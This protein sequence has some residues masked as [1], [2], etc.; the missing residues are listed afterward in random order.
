MGLTT[1]HLVP[2]TATGGTLA[3]LEHELAPRSL[4]SPL[5]THRHEDEV[6]HV[7]SG[8]L[9]VQVG[10]AVLELGPGETVAKP[11][12][13]AHAFWN[14]GDVPVRFLEVVTPAGFEAYFAEVEPLLA[15]PG[16]PDLIAVGAL[17]ARYGLEVDPFSIGALVVA[18]DLV[19]PLPG[20]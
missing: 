9:G 10:D 2:G 16:A 3:L 7:V 1:R 4:G 20:G 6:S 13:T 17:M 19:M 18:H 8:R 11:R 15:G 12:G 5:H 14:P